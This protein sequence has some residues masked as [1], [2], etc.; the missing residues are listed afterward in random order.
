MLGLAGLLSHCMASGWSWWA[1]LC[2]TLAEVRRAR[3]QHVDFTHKFPEMCFVRQTKGSV[4]AQPLPKMSL[5]ELVKEASVMRKG[6]CSLWE[7]PVSLSFSQASGT[8]KFMDG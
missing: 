5:Q 4:A 2:K 1:C 7:D 8:V 3:G 6:K